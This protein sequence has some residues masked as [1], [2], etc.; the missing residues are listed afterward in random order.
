[1]ANQIIVTAKDGAKYTLEFNRKVVET[2]ERNG[3]VIDTDRP[4]TMVTTLFLGAFRMHHRGIDPDR[5]RAIWDEQ[6]H[7][8]ELLAELISMYN[9]PLNSL[10]KDNEEA[11]AENPTWTR[12]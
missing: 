11:D 4:Y 9:V 3:F 8:D 6:N 1:M 5:V 7:K 2:M 10:M 12:A